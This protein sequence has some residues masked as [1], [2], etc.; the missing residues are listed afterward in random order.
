MSGSRAPRA[1]AMQARLR[2]SRAANQSPQANTGNIG[3]GARDNGKGGRASG[4]P[5]PE[6]SKFLTSSTQIDTV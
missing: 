5:H 4:V 1:S 6:P 3:L 2:K